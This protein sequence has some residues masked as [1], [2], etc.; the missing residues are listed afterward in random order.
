[1][2]NSILE[3]GTQAQLSIASYKM[4]KVSPQ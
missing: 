2:S 4:N 3:S 1:M